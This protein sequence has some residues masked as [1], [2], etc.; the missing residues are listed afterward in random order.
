MDTLSGK[1]LYAN[2]K[3]DEISCLEKEYDSVT[4]RRED[5][6]LDVLKGISKE[7]EGSL[8]EVMKVGG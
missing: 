2:K 6:Y 8:T 3:I 1:A 5:G 7:I 4:D